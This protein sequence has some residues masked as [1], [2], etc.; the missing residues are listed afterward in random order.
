ME[1][2]QED[3]A[4][5][6]IDVSIKKNV[7]ALFGVDIK[8]SMENLNQLVISL[9]SEHKGHDPRSH[10]DEVYHL[11]VHPNV[12]ECCMEDLFDVGCARD[13]ARISI[14]KA[15]V[16]KAK[17]SP[18]ERIVY[19]F[20]MLTKEVHNIASKLHVKKVIA[21]ADWATMMQEAYALKSQG[22]VVYVQPYIPTKQL[23]VLILQDDWMLKMCI[24]L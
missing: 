7:D 16:Q 8:R 17:V 18:V 14:R 5:A 22:K 12:I 2:N 9:Y 13:V 6:F 4:N 21:E 19:R 23:F 11:K 20:F 1:G 3:L 24:Q 15:Q 10:H